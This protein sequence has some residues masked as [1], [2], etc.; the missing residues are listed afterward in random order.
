MLKKLRSLLRSWLLTEEEIAPNPNLDC[1]I[2]GKHVLF[3]IT[4]SNGFLLWGTSKDG[5][6]L[7]GPGMA[8]NPNHFYRLWDHINKGNE[9]TW[10]DIQPNEQ[11]SAKKEDAN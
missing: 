9:F 5:V 7:L 2:D 8:C 11:S 1:V 4:G 10:A 6:Q 3:R